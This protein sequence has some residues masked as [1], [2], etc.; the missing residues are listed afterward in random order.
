MQMIGKV[1]DQ[2]CLM[3]HL[4]PDASKFATGRVVRCNGGAPLVP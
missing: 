4:T 3:L 2:G 1:S